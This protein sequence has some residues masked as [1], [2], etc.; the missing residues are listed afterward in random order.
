MVNFQ[1][2]VGGHFTLFKG[3]VD[4]NLNPITEEYIS[5]FPNL[6]LD[7]GLQRMGQSGDYCRFLHL[8]TGISEP[9][10]LQASLD[11]KVYSGNTRSPI[12]P[13]AWG[14][15]DVNDPNPYMHI[16]MRFRVNPQGVNRTYSEL[17]V[18][19]NND[20]L[21]SRTLI[22]DVHGN[23]NTISI[24]GDEYLDVLYQ[25]RF[26]V[27][28]TTSTGSFTP[29]G[30][31]VLERTFE[32]KVSRFRS[33]SF[34]FGWAIS[35]SANPSTNMVP[36]A[37]CS[38]WKN[39]AHCRFF[40]GQ[41][42]EEITDGPT[43]VFGSNFNWSITRLTDT[44]ALFKI[45]RGLPDSNG[46]IAGFELSTYMTNFQIAI[47]P[48]FVKTDQDRFEFEWTLSWGRYEGDVT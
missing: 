40:S 45:V 1:L 28:T 44:S 33:V 9:H 16:S 6:I 7:T 8:G 39:N 21:F 5:D 2:G 22:K 48:P 3:K 36:L 31:D 43:S 17:G 38:T 32:S 25:V 46:T 47:D 18:G 42:G 30:D 29:T 11:N 37:V 20:N 34:S 12:L 27:T 24:L 23:N 13:P 14:F 41:I 19:W 26:Y 35:A 10:R 4:E 15:S